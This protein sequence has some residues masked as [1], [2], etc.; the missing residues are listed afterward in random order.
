MKFDT[1]ALKDWFFDKGRRFI[2][3]NINK[4][5]KKKFDKQKELL[6]EEI[7]SHP[8]SQELINHTSPSKFLN[9]SNG[10]LFGFIGFEAGTDPV[11]DL[12]KLIRR[13]VRFIPATTINFRGLTKVFLTVPRVKDIDYYF[14]LPWEPGNSW[15]SGIENGISGLGY[16]LSKKA[17]RSQEGIQINTDINY[18]EFE[19]VDYLTPILDKFKNS[20]E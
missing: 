3:S 2:L 1:S 14:P 10:S 12:V 17:G 8:V 15:I 18:T 9:G 20:I 6:I 5:I 4:I 19:P 13:V 7:I 11:G 16:F